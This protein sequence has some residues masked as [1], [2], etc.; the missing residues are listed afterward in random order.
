MEGGGDREEEE[1]KKEMSGESKREE[2]RGRL[3]AWHERK[4]ET[5]T[6]EKTRVEGCGGAGLRAGLRV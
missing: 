5:Q 1:E 3:L 2:A 4:D 6:A